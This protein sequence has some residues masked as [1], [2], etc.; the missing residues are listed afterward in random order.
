[1]KS[2][3]QDQA[4][5]SEKKVSDE[6]RGQLETERT[7]N[8]DAMK[9]VSSSMKELQEFMTARVLEQPQER[10]LPAHTQQRYVDFY[11]IALSVAY[12]Q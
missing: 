5:I 10:E 12:N 4:L 8:G 7:R 1:M 9:E 2:I 6:L 11:G 3:E